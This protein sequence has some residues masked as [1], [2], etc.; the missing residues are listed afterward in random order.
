MKD[1]STHGAVFSPVILRSDKTTVSVAT[2]QNE[3]YLLYASTGIIQN[4]VCR[5]HQNSLGLLAFLSI[6]K[7]ELISTQVY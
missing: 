3:Y 1:P 6:P 4:H 5:V 2:R 7:S